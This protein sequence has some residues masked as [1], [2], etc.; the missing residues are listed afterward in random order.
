MSRAALRQGSAGSCA[1]FAGLFEGSARVL[2]RLRRV[3]RG[4]EKRA[5]CWEYR[6]SF[7]LTS[8]MVQTQKVTK[9]RNGTQGERDPPK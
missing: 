5:H 9:V 1:G 4:S 8:D 7:L 2:L 6:L 3:P